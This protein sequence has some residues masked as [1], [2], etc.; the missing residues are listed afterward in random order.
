MYTAVS[1]IIQ[2]LRI[3]DSLTIGEILHSK[4]LYSNLHSARVNAQKAL[5]NLADL[6]KI[7]KCK[8]YYRTPD[9]KSEYKEH[10]RLLTK[11]LSKIL[12]CSNAVIHREI[13][14]PDIGLR[15]D[16]IALLKKAGQGACFVLEVVNNESEIYLQSKINAWKNWQGSLP[17][18]SR[19]FGYS[20][21][22]FD[23]ITSDQ[24]ETYLEDLCAKF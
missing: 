11:S 19:L 22:Y 3:S 4:G 6:G 5:N 7:E 21:P 16:T 13:T 2:T 17:F 20:I 9:C 1:D 24:L 10:A 14:I 8:G 18:L 15:P 12:I 23:L